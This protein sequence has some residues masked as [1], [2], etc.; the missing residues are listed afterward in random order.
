MCSE[1]EDAGLAAAPVAL[2]RCS[3]LVALRRDLAALVAAADSALLVGE[4]AQAIDHATAAKALA[5][6]EASSAHQAASW[7][8]GVAA[9]Q[10]GRSEALESAAA[11]CRGPQKDALKALVALTRSDVDTC[12]FYTFRTPPNPSPPR[13]RSLP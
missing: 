12:P 5:T 2:R 10:L 8:A 1:R 3:G 9:W 11:A 7:T 13:L 4:P 6:D